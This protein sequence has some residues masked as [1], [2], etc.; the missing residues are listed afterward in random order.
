MKLKWIGS[1][2]IASV[3]IFSCEKAEKKADKENLGVSVDR[4]ADLEIL[5]YDIPGWD[6]LTLK[7]KE[8]VY[9]LSQAGYAGRDIIW[10]QN[11]KYNLTIRH[12]LENIFENYKGDINS[13]NWKNF[14]V[15]LKRIWF[16][17]GI[18]HHYS[19]DKIKPDFSKEYLIELLTET[20]TRLSP[21]I[22]DILFND[23]DNKKVNLDLAKGLI[24]GSAVNYYG[25][26]ITADEVE[27]FYKNMKSADSNRPTLKGL[28]SKLVKENGQLVE[29]VWKSGGMYGAA[30]DKI[31]YWLEKAEGV[32]ENQKQA[33]ALGLLIQFYKTGDLKTWDDYNIAWTEATEGNIDY[34]NGFIEVYLDPLG[35]KG[36]FESVVQ[37][38]DFDMS[39][40]MSVLSEN[41]QW[42]EDNS[43]LMDEHKK[44]NVTGVSYKTVLV[45]S[46]SGDA[47]PSTPIG[48]NLPN[49]DWIRAEHGS[50]SVSLGNII[51]AYN[52]AGG[53]GRLKEFANDAE[54]IALAEKYGDLASKLHTALHEVIGHASGQLNPGV[55]VPKETLKSYASTLEEGRAD[56]V[57]LYFLYTP[58]LQELGLVDDWKSVG[59]AAYDNYIRNG[60]MLQLTRLNL[61]DNIEESHMRNRQ[62]VS[63][64]VFEKGQKD[65]VIEKITRDGKT[66]FNINDYEKLHELFGQ[67]LK[68]AQRMKSEGDYEAA[69]NLVEG[70]GVK[71]DQ[72]IHKEVLERNS[73]FDIAPYRGFVNPYIEPVTNSKGEVTDY[74]LKQPKT[75][76]E[77]M[78]S[79]AK[80]YGV[81]PLNN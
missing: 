5:R 24:E 47:S 21:K 73:Q 9:Y 65:N 70:Y 44:K 8:Y 66:Y 60:L 53:A 63:A 50:K 4:F 43:P 27:A 52:K 29:K 54:E 67:L 41:A 12:A 15:Y 32:A 28:N 19:N 40:K 48:I 77:Q 22:V 13:E 7:E 42:F 16:S 79:Y 55:G 17:N 3:L 2:M 35:H 20:D 46:E 38:N 72:A 56:L 64:W 26:D 31:I 69:K 1:L 25:D 68:E 45:T 14:V 71:V 18:H 75:F 23:E 78:L 49:S 76:E 61:G 10:D 62:W 36:S 80:E 33:D 34:I 59:M 51:D 11:Y 74:V 58:K 81:L 6:N 57:G 30:I 37:I 39:K